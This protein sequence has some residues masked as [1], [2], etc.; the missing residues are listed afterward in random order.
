MEDKR[1]NRTRVRTCYCA[2]TGSD[3][4]AAIQAISK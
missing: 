1:H 4:T 2:P 3:I